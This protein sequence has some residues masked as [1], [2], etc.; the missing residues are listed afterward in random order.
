MGVSTEGKLKALQD[1]ANAVREQLIG[2]LD[3]LDKMIRDA[4]LGVE[5]L[6]DVQ[7]LQLRMDRMR[8]REKGREMVGSLE[9]EMK[10]NHPDRGKILQLRFIQTLLLSDLDLGKDPR[11]LD[12]FVKAVDKFG[13]AGGPPTPTDVSF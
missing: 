2:Q 10:Q 8:L 1:A 5:H 4:K 9:R 3:L 11:M 6:E 13:D 7:E 12:A